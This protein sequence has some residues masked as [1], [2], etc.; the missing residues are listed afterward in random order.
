MKNNNNFDGKFLKVKPLT[1]EDCGFNIPIPRNIL[2]SKK[3]KCP[4]CGVVYSVLLLPN[5]KYTFEKFLED[6]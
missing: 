2:F 5:N 4:S 3:L 1:C 6:N